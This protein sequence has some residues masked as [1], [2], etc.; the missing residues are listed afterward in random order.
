MEYTITKAF[1]DDLKELAKV[2]KGAFKKHNIFQKD[3]DSI[4]NYLKSLKDAKVLVAKSDEILGGIVVRKADQDIKGNHVVFKYNHLAVDADYE[5]EGIAK[6]LL[7][8]ADED[9]KNKIKYGEIDTA[10][11]EVSVA[12]EEN[13]DLYKEVGFELEGELKSHYRHGENVY[14]MGKLIE[15]P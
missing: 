14:I 10:K 3:R 15:E 13:L 2:Y 1:K 4:V 12:D 8:S 5:G 11:I 9:I 7:E 6:D